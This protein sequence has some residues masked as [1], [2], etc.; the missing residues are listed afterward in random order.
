MKCSPIRLVLLAAC[1][2]GSVDAQGTRADYERAAGLRARWRGKLQSFRPSL[3][4]LPNDAG[5]WWRDRRAPKDA[6]YVLVDTKTG[7]RRTAASR[8]GLGLPG[9]EATLAPQAT[10]S[11]SARTGGR[12]S[13]HFENRLDRTVRV[14]WV[15]TSGRT[16]QYGTI[17]PGAKRTLSTFA[18]HVWLLDFEADDLAG[19]FTAEDGPGTAIIDAKS[20][21]LTKRGRSRRGGTRARTR[22]RAGNGGFKT[23]IEDYNVVGIAPDGARF[24]LTADGTEKNG[25]RRPQSWSPDGTKVLGMRVARGDRRRV[26]MV[27]SSPGDQIQPR[28]VDMGYAKPGDRLDQPTPCLFDLKTRRRIPV[29]G[30]LFS[31]VYRLNRMRWSAD[32]KRVF[33]VYNRRGHQ[34]LALMSIDAITGKV[35]DVVRETSPTFVD[36]SQKF[37]LRWIRG[38]KELLWASERDGHNHLYRFASHGELLSQVTAGSWMM[39]KVEHVDEAKGQV[40]FTAMGLVPGQDPYHRHLARVDLDGENL[41]VLTA[42]DGTHSW[43]FSPGRRFFIDRWSRVDRPPV[44]ELRRTAD[45]K[46]LATLGADDDAKLRAAGYTPPQRFV[47]KGRD[48]KT[49]I[50]GILIRPSNFDATK[51]YPV[52]EDIYAGPHDHHVPKSY[53]VGHRQ[54]L[55]AELGFIVVR[56]DGMGTNWRS[57]AFHDVCWQNLKDG[58]FPD[59]I[60]WL[61]A[62]AKVHPELDL[63]HVGIFGGSAGGQNALAGLLHHGDF[64]DAGVADC[65]CHDNRM[66]KIW[67]NEAWMGKLGPHYAA[68][69]NV[70]HAG[71][72]RGKLMLTVGELDR[73]VDPASTMQVVN[74]LIRADRDFDLIVV[75]GGGHGVGER[76]YLVRRRQDFFVRALYGVEPRR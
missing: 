12:T 14:F 1:L 53:R 47:A 25:Y 31:D 69:S 22:T 2:A 33:L 26:T 40:W 76:P 39:R 45:G 18:G 28:T 3:R 8:K 70:T 49:D 6:R 13:I 41:V 54:R 59:R 9:G 52:I 73:N 34:E 71:K 36:Y 48:G 15:D 17:A 23:R 30:A 75:P 27:E 4:W 50:H 67:W 32:S 68:S 56:I 74:A 46:L 38:G 24:K 63:E 60:A 20:R 21:K 7:A 35:A 51:H 44:T 55:L 64:Y 57:K 19:I 66:D 65:G 42:G 62:A 11:R 16:K 29:D 43:T 72:L 58:G 37:F 10:W 5:V 61:R